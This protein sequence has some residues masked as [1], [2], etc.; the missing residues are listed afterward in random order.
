MI[1]QNASAH[2]TTDISFTVPKTDLAASVETAQAPR[3]SSG[4]RA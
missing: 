2:G 3:T 1:V 4:P